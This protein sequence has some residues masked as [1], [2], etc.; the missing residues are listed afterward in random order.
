M[1]A[2]HPLQPRLNLS[3]LLIPA[4]AIVIGACGFN[5]PE[6]SLENAENCDNIAVL[7][8]DAGTVARWETQ[9]RPALV[10]GLSSALPDATVSYANSNGS[11]ETQ[12]QQATEALNNGACIL[13]VAAE[14]STDPTLVQDAEARLVPVIAYDRL[15]QADELTAYVSF[16]GFKVGELQ[17]Q[18]IVEQHS[19]GDR[20]VMINGSEDDNNAIAF[21]EGALSQLQPLADQ[22]EISIIFDEYIDGWNDAVAQATM[23]DLIEDE[24]G[25][26]Q[27]AYVANDGMASGVI[28][29]LRAAGLNGEVLVTGQDASVVA[30]RNILLGDQSMT[31]Y[32]PIPQQAQATI[33][34]VM[35][36]IE[37][38]DLA[39]ITSETVALASGRPI[40]FVKLTPIR[41]TQDNMAETVIRDGFASQDEICEDLPAEV[42]FVCL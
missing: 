2:R 32:K 26:I 29:A 22:G 17:G 39:E 3:L 6:T 14:D 10:D 28:S 13:I 15:I 21:R 33:E 23:E 11:S 7:L 30:L 16:D 27:I 40:P 36:M 42:E 37:G 35:A 24:E 8:P 9:D 12:L 18:F 25:N 31:V 19:P 5:Q 38:K 20:V 34:I 4:A 41:V 1:I